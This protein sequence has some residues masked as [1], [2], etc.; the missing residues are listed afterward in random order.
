MG[1]DAQPAA[2]PPYLS[3]IFSETFF[4]FMR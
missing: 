4:R 1:M 2:A 3:M